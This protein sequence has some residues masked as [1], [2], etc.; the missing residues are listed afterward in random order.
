MIYFDL[1][2]VLA[3]FARGVEMFCGLEPLDQ[4]VQDEREQ[5]MWEAIRQVDRFYAKLPAT[6]GGVALFHA[7]Y[8]R[9]GP[10]C[11]ILTGIPKPK[12]GIL[13]AGEDKTTWVRQTLSPDVKIN[14]VFKEQ[15]KEFCS[16][17][18]CIL[19][20]DF[21]KNVADWESYGGTGILYSSAAQTLESLQALGVLPEALPERT[22][23]HFGL[24]AK[25]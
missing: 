12:R 1:D 18:E 5:R 23:V 6:P 17:P 15:K 25:G 20:D 8:D 21:A 13:T 9:Y 11:E 22:D 7:V 3:D 24:P 2:G 4:S 16:G 10:C 14:L 19:I